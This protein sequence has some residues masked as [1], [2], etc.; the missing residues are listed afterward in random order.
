MLFPVLYVSAKVITRVPLVKAT[1]MDFISGVS[2]I[3]AI[4]SVFTFLE[5]AL[6]L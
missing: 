1:E 4:T 3:D 5:Q 6:P 2:E